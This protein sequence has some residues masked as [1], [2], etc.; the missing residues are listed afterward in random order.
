M[1]TGM[2]WAA[3]SRL[4]TPLMWFQAMTSST[5]VVTTEVTITSEMVR[6]S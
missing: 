1:A 6:N 5:A 2:S 3:V 4:L